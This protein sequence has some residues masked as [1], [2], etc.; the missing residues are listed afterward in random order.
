MPVF[1]VNKTKNFTIMSNFHFQEKNMSLKAK[2]LLSQMLSLPDDWEYSLDGICSMCNDGQSSVKS[3][4]SE[5]K[6][7]GYLTVTKMMPNETKSKKIEYLYNVYEIPGMRVN[8]LTQDGENK[9]PQ[10]RTCNQ[11]LADKRLQSTVCNQSLEMIP[12]LNTNNKILNN[13]ILNN[14]IL[15]DKS[16]NTE[17]A[18]SCDIDIIEQRFDRFYAVY[19]RKQARADARKAFKKIKPSEEL[20][21]VMIAA[22]EEQKTW[23]GWTK[24]GGQ[25]IPLPATWLNRGQWEDEKPPQK[26]EETS[27]PFLQ[28][29]DEH[30]EDA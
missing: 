9:N 4:L 1:R 19:P 17:H 15:N 20:L 14:K 2:G 6:S 7:L 11:E 24:D 25:F 26:A 29:L 18:N 13:K 3:A 8:D 16:P 23:D 12:Q 10:P 30:G 27:N 21:Q 5:L 22:V 28:W